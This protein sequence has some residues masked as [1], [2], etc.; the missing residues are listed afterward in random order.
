M[1]AQGTTVISQNPLVEGG[2]LSDYCSCFPTTRWW[3]A[4]LIYLYV[5]LIRSLVSCYKLRA[6]VLYVLYAEVRRF[7]KARLSSS[8]N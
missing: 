7:S 4:L 1:C 8:M 2:R 6:L 3:D 5:L